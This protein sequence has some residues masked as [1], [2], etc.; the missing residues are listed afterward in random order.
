MPVQ[1]KNQVVLVVG[2]SSG[3]G[4]ATAVLFAREGCRV[5]ASARRED[6]L[7]GLQKQLAE[8][9]HAIEIASADAAK[10]KDMEQL[11]KLTHDKFSS[12]P[13]EPIRQ[14]ARRSG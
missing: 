14:T 6:R 13:L 5:M 1:L 8:E 7:L 9:G 11:A 2:A 4:R 10:V 12:S 3:I